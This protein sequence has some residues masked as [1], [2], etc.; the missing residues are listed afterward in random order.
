[1]KNTWKP[2]CG[3][4]IPSD[5][6]NYKQAIKES[7]R[8]WVITRAIN[9]YDQDGEYFECVFDHKPTIEE[10]VKYTEQDKAYAQ[11]LLNGGGRIKVENEWYYLTEMKSGEQYKHKHK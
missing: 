9:Q 1:M 11:Y 8:M 2:T 5:N 10:L 4:Y 7:N 6:D 3:G